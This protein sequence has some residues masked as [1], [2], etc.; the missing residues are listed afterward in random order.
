MLT[1]F[2]PCSRLA[3]IER[4]LSILVDSKIRNSTCQDVWLFY[5]RVEIFSTVKIETDLLV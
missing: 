4:G 1:L 3:Y 2:Q 5:W